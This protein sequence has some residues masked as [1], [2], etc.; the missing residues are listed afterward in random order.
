[1]S[2]LAQLRGRHVSQSYLCA[3]YVPR[4]RHH[5]WRCA[6]RR[7]HICERLAH[8]CYL[9]SCSHQRLDPR[10]HA[11]WI[12]I[13]LSRYAR[14]CL[15][16]PFAIVRNRERADIR[17]FRPERTSITPSGPSCV[18]SERGRHPMRRPCIS[19]HCLL[20][21]QCKS[22]AYCEVWEC[23]PTLE[24]DS[25]LFCIQSTAL[26]ISIVELINHAQNHPTAPRP[27]RRRC[28]IQ[29]HHT[30]VRGGW[31]QPCGAAS[32]RGPE[33]EK[34]SVLMS[35]RLAIFSCTVTSVV[36]HTRWYV[37]ALFHSTAFSSQ[38]TR[39]RRVV[40]PRAWRRRREACRRA[41]S[42]WRRWCVEACRGRILHSC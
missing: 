41:R 23:Q 28:R 15:P 6:P 31:L 10:P 22:T 4:G 17:P 29:P 11:M 1:M 18:T 9:I 3:H 35:V 5:T 30:S 13:A 37:Y 32:V 27:G 39:Q 38:R 2:R 34:G 40:P 19:H 33:K 20:T 21:L 26:S 36:T 16:L 7:T 12:S 8:L 25:L 14:L 24:V 42:G